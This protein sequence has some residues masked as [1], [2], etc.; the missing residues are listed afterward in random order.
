MV[1]PKGISN[2]S[3]RGRLKQLVILMIAIIVC[4][5][6]AQVVEAGKRSSKSATI[7]NRK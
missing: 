5:V 7:Q 2:I 4:I 1:Q 6:I 3:F